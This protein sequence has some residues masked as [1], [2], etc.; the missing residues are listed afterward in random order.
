MCLNALIFTRHFTCF[1]E[2]LK[3]LK[4]LFQTQCYNYHAALPQWMRMTQDRVCYIWFEPMNLPCWVPQKLPLHILAFNPA[5]TTF[6]SPWIKLTLCS[7]AIQT[8]WMWR[9]SAESG[10]VA[11]HSHGSTDHLGGISLHPSNITWGFLVSL[12]NSLL[13]VHLIFSP[14]LSKNPNKCFFEAIFSQLSDWLLDSRG[15]CWFSKSLTA[16]RPGKSIIL[17]CPWSK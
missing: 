12:K 15:H 3:G 17:Q 9:C 13:S 5:W 14:L 6:T 1:Q 2:P 16:K 11:T 10:S 4:L 8:L 7:N